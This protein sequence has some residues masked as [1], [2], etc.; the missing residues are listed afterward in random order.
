M[1]TASIDVAPPRPAAPLEA[2]IASFEA[3][4]LHE[5]RR[6]ARTVET[7]LRDLRAFAAFLEANGAEPDADRVTVVTLRAFLAE[8]MRARSSATTARTISAL[9]SF[10]RYLLRKRLIGQNPAAALKSPKRRR[11]A[12]DFLTVDQAFRVVEAPSEDAGRDEP[13]Q[14]RDRAILELLYGTG[15]R[16]SEL[17]GLSLADVSLADRAARLLG[18]GNKERIV[19]LGG[20]CV[21][22]LEAYLAVRPR[23]VDRHG[24][25]EPDALFLGRFGTRLTARQVQNVVRRYGAL[26]AARGDLHPHALRHTC[27]THLLDAGADLRVIQELLGHSSLSTTQRY[28]HVSLDRLMEVY[29]RAHPLARGDGALAPRASSG[30]ARAR[31]AADSKGDDAGE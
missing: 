1:P 6:S 7:Y 10:F 19:P 29:D 8:R 27:A 17:A 31:T 21:E 25:Q 16:V 24:E 28:T 3:Y 12:P 14:R 13:L 23:L 4:L 22:A 11:G 18:K 20:P 5:R 15:A 26:G 9:R 2:Q 30:A